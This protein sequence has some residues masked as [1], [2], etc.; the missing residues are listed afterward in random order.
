MV[1]DT[2]RNGE[3]HS[4][5]EDITLHNPSRMVKVAHKAVDKMPHDRGKMLR[6]SSAVS[7]QQPWSPSSQQLGLQL[8]IDYKAKVMIQ[9]PVE[10]TYLLQPIEVTSLGTTLRYDVVENFMDAVGVDHV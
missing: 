7:R 8:L 3:E 1:L 5:G 9:V 6:S 4:G 2:S 10:R